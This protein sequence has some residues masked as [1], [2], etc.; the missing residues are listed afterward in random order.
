VVGVCIVYFVTIDRD[1]SRTIG[2]WLALYPLFSTCSLV[3]ACYLTTYS[4][5]HIIMLTKQ[6]LG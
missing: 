4:H 6:S 2:A 5:K 1:R 3:G